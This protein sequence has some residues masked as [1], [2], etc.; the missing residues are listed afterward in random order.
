M[1][2]QRSR[3]VPCYDWH[4]S[5][6]LFYIESHYLAAWSA[7]LRVVCCLRLCIWVPLWLMITVAGSWYDMSSILPFPIYSQ[8]RPAGRVRFLACWNWNFNNLERMRGGSL[9]W[10]MVARKPQSVTDIRD[11][12]IFSFS[13]KILVTFPFFVTKPRRVYFSIVLKVLK[14]DLAS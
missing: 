11:D 6:R 2:E 5:L 4:S 12:V 13:Q 3:R 14:L 7:D 1:Q 8:K 10:E 9:F